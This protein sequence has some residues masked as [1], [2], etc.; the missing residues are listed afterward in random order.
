MIDAR[1]GWKIEHVEVIESKVRTEATRLKTGETKVFISEYA[2]G[3][4][5]ASS[6]VRRSLGMPLD[7]GP[8]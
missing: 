7:G 5:G 8:V 3:C 6:A 1:Y 4:D 2:V